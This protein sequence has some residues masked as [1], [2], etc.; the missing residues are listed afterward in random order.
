MG[1]AHILMGFA[2]LLTG[3]A[4]EPGQLSGAPRR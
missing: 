4:D 1:C 2:Q 3:F